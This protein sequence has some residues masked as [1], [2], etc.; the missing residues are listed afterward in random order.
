MSLAYDYQRAID[1]AQTLCEIVTPLQER[2]RELWP[3]ASV[4]LTYLKWR[5]DE[6]TNEILAV[7]RDRIM[8]DAADE[9]KATKGGA[10]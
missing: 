6:A 2:D 9:T 10:K 7:R 8:P 3:S 5:L 1:A 4:K